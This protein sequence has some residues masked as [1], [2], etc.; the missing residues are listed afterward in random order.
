MWHYYRMK[1]TNAIMMGQIEDRADKQ[2]RGSMWRACLAIQRSCGNE[3]LGK[4]VTELGYRYCMGTDTTKH[5]KEICSDHLHDSDGEFHQALRALENAIKM[6][7][8]GKKVIRSNINQREGLW[9]RLD[10]LVK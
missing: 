6:A 2:D 9:L 4:L 5:L 10:R 3:A 1:F 7:P 8:K